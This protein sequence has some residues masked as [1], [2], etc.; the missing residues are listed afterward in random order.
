MFIFNLTFLLPRVNIEYIS[1]AHQ[2]NIDN[3]KTLM[4]VFMKF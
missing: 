2:I 3:F 1:Q 4:E